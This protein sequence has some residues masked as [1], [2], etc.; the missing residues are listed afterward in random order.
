MK[1]KILSVSLVLVLAVAFLFTACAPKPAV[2][3]P[4]EEFHWIVTTATTGGTYYPVGMAMATLWT[5]ELKAQGITVAGMSSA[6]SAENIIMLKGKEVELAILQGMFGKCAIKGIELYEGKPYKELRTITNLWPNVEH[7][8]INADKAKTGN[9]MDIK[10]LKFCIG[11]AGSGTEQSTSYI[12]KG[13][14]ISLDDITNMPMGYMEAADAMVDGRIDGG[15]FVAGP[16]VAAITKLFATP[17]F[18]S[19][20]LEFTD[21]QL[22][23]VNEK[24][25]YPGGRYIIPAGTYAGQDKEV[26]TIFQPNFLGCRADIDAEVVYLLTKTLF[27]EEGYKYLSGA[28]AMCKFITLESAIEALPAPLH[29]GAY[30]FYKE[31]GLTIPA[32][33]IPPEVK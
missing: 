4:K 24:T 6:G 18:K 22:K 32:E 8:A 20:L 21:E 28:H 33:L 9:V 11:S 17:R 16:P 29:P 27:T 31:K 12:M 15:S 14:G 25:P 10:G 2:E 26:H 19:V 7:F 30:K 13:C 23:A 3:V 1:K 5:K